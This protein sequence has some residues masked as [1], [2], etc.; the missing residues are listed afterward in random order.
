MNAVVARGVEFRYGD[1]VA[2]SA[3]DFSVPV[4]KI[5]AVIGP[6]GSGKST[7]LN[8]IAGLSEPDRGSIQAFGAAPGEVRRRIAYVLQS[9]RV[10]EMMHVTVR[11]VVAMG[12]YAALG[13]FGR[14]TGEDRAAIDA[15]L[16]RMGIADL[17]PRH[18]HELSGGQRQR[19]FVAQGLAQDRDM[20]LLDEPL[21]GLDIVSA[22]TIDG[23]IH[24]EA[25]QG[26]TVVLTTHDLAEASVSDHVVL[27]SGRVIASGPPRQVLTPDHLSAAYGAALLHAEGVVFLDDP[28]H[29]PANPSHS[30]SNRGLPLEE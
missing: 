25:D 17:G 13:V 4:G 12:R 10:N 11:E 27:L 29:R 24:E 5:T 3:S 2:I 22:E 19:V 6:N 8:L 15:A 28:A 18:L 16:D 7:L 23:V 9:A 21:T 30:H 1:R 14:F 26:R 20:L